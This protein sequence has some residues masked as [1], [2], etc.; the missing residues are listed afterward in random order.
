MQA[1][2]NQK[3]I[4]KI[5][6][7]TF[8]VYHKVNSPQACFIEL[9]VFY[10]FMMSVESLIIYGIGFLYTF[11]HGKWTSPA[12]Y[13]LCFLSSHILLDLIRSKT[14]NGV[15]FCNKF[16][17]EQSYLTQIRWHVLGMAAYLYSGNLKVMI[18]LLIWPNV[19]FY[20]LVPVTTSYG[21]SVLTM[22]MKVLSWGLKMSPHLLQCLY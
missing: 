10:L 17:M 4:R 16:S 11:C 19:S 18:C 21:F 5:L 20:F 22:D 6:G 9:F 15:C 14:E 7:C 8:A 13:L 12:Y 1:T 2:V 3:R